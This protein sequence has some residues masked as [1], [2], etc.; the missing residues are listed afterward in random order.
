M[1][2]EALG[3]RQ[4]PQTEEGLNVMHDIGEKPGVGRYCCTDCSWSVYLDDPDDALP[5]CGRCGPGQRTKYQR[6]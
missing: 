1:A 5:P 2:Q 4:T 3:R 6:C